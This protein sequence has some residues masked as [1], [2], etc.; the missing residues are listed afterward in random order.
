MKRKAGGNRSARRGSTPARRT[1]RSKTA[2]ERASKPRT[3]KSASKGRSKRKAGSQRTRPQPVTAIMTHDVQ[4]LRPDTPV[5]EVAARM[6][7]LNVGA[8]PVCDGDRLLG[9][10]TDRD[11]VVRT[12][13]ERRN[14]ED[15]RASDVMSTDLVYCFEDQDTEE[16]GRLMQEKQIRRLPVV[17][18]DRRLVGIVSLG[19]LAVQ[20]GNTGLSG[21]TLKD[22]SAPGRS[23]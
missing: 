9:M 15:T 16:A 18:R 13:A 19:D 2:G 11:I 5:V 10:I 20:T 6:K 17:N 23:G 3:G 1:T 22:I 12:V 7:T 8:I 4:T 21:K 14:P